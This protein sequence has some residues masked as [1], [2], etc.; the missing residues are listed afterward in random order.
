MLGCLHDVVPDRVVSAC[1]N[2]HMWVGDSGIICAGARGEDD[3]VWE[4]AAA[5]G[6]ERVPCAEQVRFLLLVLEKVN[7][8]VDDRCCCVELTVEHVPDGGDEV[9]R[10]GLGCGV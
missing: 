7:D 9:T 5:L 6:L 2:Q 3:Q 1:G 8:E 10:A 4:L